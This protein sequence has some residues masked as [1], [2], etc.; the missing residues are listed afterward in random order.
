MKCHQ[1]SPFDDIRLNSKFC[2]IIHF[3]RI[4]LKKKKKDR[5]QDFLVGASGNRRC[6]ALVYV[7][8]AT[9]TH[10]TSSRGVRSSSLIT[11][12]TSLAGPSRQRSPPKATPVPKV[13]SATSSKPT[14]SHGNLAA[15]S[16]NAPSP[17]RRRSESSTRSR[18]TDADQVLSQ[19]KNTFTTQQRVEFCGN[20]PP[21]KLALVNSPYNRA[22]SPSVRLIVTS[23]TPSRGP[24]IV[25]SSSP[26][27]HSFPG[28]L[29][30][31]PGTTA[32]G[33]SMAR[34]QSPSA[35]IATLPRS[36]FMG[37]YRGGASSGHSSS[38]ATSTVPSTGSSSK[39]NSFQQFNNYSGQNRGVGSK[40]MHALIY[41]T[42]HK[43]TSE[44]TPHHTGIWNF[45]RSSSGPADLPIFRE[46]KMYGLSFKRLS[47]Q[48]QKSSWSP[49]MSPSP[50]SKPFSPTT[51]AESVVSC[52]PPCVTVP[53]AAELPDS[54]LSQ[55]KVCESFGFVL[56]S[57][58]EYTP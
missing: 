27:Q 51:P 18:S 35:T 4:N 8:A 57:Y 36:T 49:K 22:T 7:V 24:G 3:L 20:S 14:A 48:Q 37:Q 29:S 31:I 28:N 11:Q 2:S 33:S 1:M 52:S 15:A 10:P 26:T 38:S 13:Q 45:G 53:A 54:T 30:I 40:T 17:S 58:E 9:A 32:N 41:P 39:I 25:A 21:S 42:S 46:L 5:P 47:A 43:T 50:E 44:T 6:M 12:T 23:L 16:T 34:R 19:Q 55:N 56:T